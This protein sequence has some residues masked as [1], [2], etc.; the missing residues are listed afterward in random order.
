MGDVVKL[1]PKKT[2]LQLRCVACGA[3]ADAACDCGVAYKPANEIAEAAIKANPK[4]SD[5]A[6]SK[7][8]GISHQTIGRTRKSTGPNGPVALR[9]GLD[10]KTRKMP[11]PQAHPSKFTTQQLA[12]FKDD[13][14]TDFDGPRDF[15][16]RTISNT[17]SDILAKIPFWNKTYPKWR[18]YELDSDILTL[19]IDAAEAWND[20]VKQLK[21]LKQ[22]KGNGKSQ[23]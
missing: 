10:G 8:H 13:S 15:W 23:K 3:T 17:A 2:P 1:R 5:R 9:V 21:R 20:L 4:M 7:K 19:A 22:E 18:T 6:L 16:Q 12:S 14:A 11:K